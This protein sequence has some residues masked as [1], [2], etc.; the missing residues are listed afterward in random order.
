MLSNIVKLDAD[1]EQYDTIYSDLQGVLRQINESISV[2]NGQIEEV[3]IRLYHAR[4]GSM[5][6][7]RMLQIVN[8]KVRNVGTWPADD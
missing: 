8:E 3:G 2:L 5:S 4:E 1:D 7:E 6:Q